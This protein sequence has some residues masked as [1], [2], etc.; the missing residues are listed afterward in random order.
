MV[1]GDSLPEAAAR[2]LATLPT[3]GRVH[4][5]GFSLGAIVAFEVLRR[6]PERLARLTLLGANPHAP[7]PLQLETWAAH[8]RQVRAG[9][10]GEVAE[11]LA[12]GAGPNRGAVLEMARR[13]GPEVYL[14]QLGL[15]RSR[16]DSRADVA[17]FT[18]P[19]TLLVGAE[20]TVTPPRLAEDL[21][22]FAPH[23]SVRIVPEA[24][25]YLPLDAPDAVSDTLNTV[26]HA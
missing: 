2:V 8:E 5:V 17:R 14:E 21:R 9:H 20:D 10:F 6:A 4:L 22:S 24:G 18:G 19:L 13:V 11:A 7:T 16:P 15:L 23:A 1:R 25:H 26:A 12:G 3:G